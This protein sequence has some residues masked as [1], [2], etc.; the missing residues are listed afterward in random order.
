MAIYKVRGVGSA[1][2]IKDTPPFENPSNVWTDANNV[3]F[4]RNSIEK[5]GGYLPVLTED[6]P[7]EIPLA[8]LQ[9]GNT[10]SLIYGTETS[11]YRVDG[12]THL[13]ISKEVKVDP[14]DTSDDPPMKPFTYSAA[15]ESTWYYTTLSNSIVMNNIIDVPQG[16][17]PLDDKFKDLPGWGYPLGLEGKHVTWRC[18]RLRAFKN[19]L[20]ALNMVEEGREFPQR[21]RWSNVSYVNDLP[22]DWIENDISKDG[23]FNDLS[24]SVGKIVDGVPLRDSFVIY[25]D[26]ETYLMDYIG[27]TLIF[28]FKKLYSD[29]GLLAPECAVEFEGKHFVISQDDIFVHNGSSRQPVASGRVKDFLID[30]ISSVNPA[31]TKVVALPHTKEIWICYVGPGATG[32]NNIGWSTNKAAVW[33]WEFDTWSFYDLPRSFDINLALPPD[34]DAR[35]WSEYTE[36]NRDEWEAMAREEEQWESFG[37][38]FVRKVLWVASEDG[39]L[40]LL[41]EGAFIKTY[42]K[43]TKETTS[44]PLVAFMERTHIDFDDAVESTKAYKMIRGI[45]PQFQ[46]TGVITVFLG[47]SSNATS[48]PRWEEN[49]RFDI[50]ADVKVDFRNTERYPCIRFIDY[51]LG[52]WRFAGYDI[53]FLVSGNR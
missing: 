1:G 4:L 34:R 30:E 7:E 20:V 47:G 14:D 35:N 12:M 39:C 23:G 53:D 52:E 19:Y 6:M 46:G 11:L 25:T 18:G 44:S 10:D 13:N 49:S 26:Q 42:N 40:Y 36:E 15:P 51:S 41:D 16:L 8:V 45:V 48:F 17:T 3:R 27:G 5:M 31:A 37:K 28:N 9:R 38:D 43:E 21:V 50:D 24:D 22:P 2:V 33:N 32:E 29:S